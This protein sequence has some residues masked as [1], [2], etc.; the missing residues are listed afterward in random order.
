[1]KKTPFLLLFLTLF[2]TA[3]R[4]GPNYE[5][6]CPSVPEDWKNVAQENTTAPCVD[7]WWEV[8]EDERLNELAGLAV[9]NNYNLYQALERM[10]EAR[11]IAGITRSALFP[12]FTLL[13]QY[14]NTETLTKLAG[15]NQI[16]L[17]LGTTIPPVT[18]VHQMQ[19]TFPIN[20]IYEVDLWGQIRSIWDSALYTAQ[21]RE[22][23]AR[24]LL[25]SLTADLAS[26]YF[27]LRAL[28]SDILMLL[29]IIESRKTSLRLV[30]KRNRSGLVNELDVARAQ[31]QLTNAE[32]EYHD[33]VRQR[34]LL[35]N[36]IA[37]LIGVP[38][39]D[40][41]LP[42]LPL[43][44]DPP[45][46]PAGIPSD[47]LL[48]RPD[49][50]E[51]ERS[52]ASAHALIGA[53]YA[54][55]FP[56]LN[57]TGALGFASPDLKH[58]F[59][60]SSRFWSLGA[61]AAQILFDA[62]RTGCV[63]E[64]TWARFHQAKGNY[65]QTVLQAFQDVEDALNNIEQQAKQ[66]QSLYSSVQAATKTFQLSN[67]RYLNGLGN[68]LDV[69]D[70]QRE[71][72]SAKRSWINVQGARYISTINLIKALGGGWGPVKTPDCQE[73]SD[74]IALGITNECEAISSEEVKEAA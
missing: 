9:L 43:D 20:M 24:S 71:E 13:P 23:A 56:F 48:R 36:S 55:Y 1:M 8:F 31:L 39:S 19:Y 38:A 72:L 49:I 5:P 11:A 4:I 45:I 59:S 35:E 17:P 62:G 30:E 28:D 52:M 67:R 2:F 68:Y 14:S 29:D 16:P 58:F 10:A 69:M 18:R 12:Q 73:Q 25:L 65:Q 57:L 34:M 74:E 54:S 50:A 6:P 70:S 26:Y 22:E 21:A 51:A 47:V 60:W 27:N 64:A 41:T 37:T 7:V 32:A 53:S 66:A 15:I 42:Q 33:A 63:V 40:F 44:V 3:C 46:I 61:T